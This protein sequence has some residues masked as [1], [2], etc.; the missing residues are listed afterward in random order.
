[1][2]L[3]SWPIDDKGIFF[4]D[5][6]LLRFQKRTKMFTLDNIL[7]TETIGDVIESLSVFFT[8]QLNFV[9][10][11]RVNEAATGHIITEKSRSWQRIIS[12]AHV[13]ESFHQF[14]NLKSAYKVQREERRNHEPVDVRFLE[15]FS[16]NERWFRIFRCIWIVVESLCYQNVCNC[17]SLFFMH[18]Q[19]SSQ[20][21]H[22][23][24]WDRTPETRNE[25][26]VNYVNV[27][28]ADAI[29]AHK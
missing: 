14:S 18:Y 9:V 29:W 6:F 12:T 2:S 28:D 15:Y 17:C 23:R 1:M 16:H 7:H 25:M 13:L 11:C 26:E 3:G 5:D 22:L 27:D 4:V 19:F 10:T 21:T 24:W 20:G 8:Q